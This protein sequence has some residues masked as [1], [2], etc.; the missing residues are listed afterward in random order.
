M[1]GKLY[2]NLYIN[3]YYI[4]LYSGKSFEGTAKIC[5]DSGNATAAEGRNMDFFYFSPGI[6]QTI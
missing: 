4:F 2:F 1:Y 5:E 3:L 6:R